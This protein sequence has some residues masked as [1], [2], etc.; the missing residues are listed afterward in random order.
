M[1]LEIYQLS[2]IFLIVICASYIQS[3][4]G[5]GFGIFAMILL[6][7]ILAYTAANVLSSMLSAFTS[8][9]LL[10]AMRKHLNLKN[11]IKRY[12]Q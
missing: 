1:T 3:V 8:V 11:I 6:P 2:I 5:F 4:T 12:H 7:Y 10:F 9:A